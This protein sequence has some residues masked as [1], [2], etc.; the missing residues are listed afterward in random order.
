MH[1]RAHSPF[2]SIWPALAAACL[3]LVACDSGDGNAV[4]VVVIGEAGQASAN[5][6]FAS[7]ARLPL[8]A[9][10]VRSATAEGLVGLDEEGRVI[11]ALADRWIVTNDGR[12]YIFRLA[13]GTWAD[14]SRITGESVQV[15]LRQAL[16]AQNGTALGLDLAGITDVRAMA[17]RVVEIRLSSPM[18]DLLQLLAQPELGL[19]HRGKGAGPMALAR[20]GNLALLTPIP[21]EKRGVAPVDNWA[22]VARPLSLRASNG[23]EAIAAFS[24]GRADVVLGGTFLDLPRT[25]HTGLGNS[26]ARPDRVAGLF[27]LMVTRTTG[28]L[29]TPLMREAVAMAID[30]DALA[31][32]LGAAGWTVSTRI[33]SPGMEG[34]AGLVGERW[35]DLDIDSRRT[36]AQRRVSV[37]ATASRQP[38][39]LWINLPGG[40]GADILFT[41]LGRDLGAI[42]ISLQRTGKADQ[43]DVTL[44]DSVAR[45]PHVAWFLNALSCRASRPA[46]SPVADALAE[47]ARHA[48]DGHTASLLWAQAET[49]LTQNNGFIPLGPPIR[50]SLVNRQTSGFSINRLGAHPL[51]PLAMRTK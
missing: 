43:A 13:D 5:S 25:H 38:P 34:D 31:W 32:Q 20:R 15:A 51:M 21:P 10:L 17:G 24:A 44:V 8:A 3:G 19:M 4:K 12:H 22:D 28:L 9:G 18:P 45:Y 48:P 30:R 39:T 7:G 36:L 41:N 37:W 1:P 11:P 40:P 27:G 46:C 33:V 49:V 6:P 35:Q 2:R 50:W 42:G 29:S 16:D 14:N 47:R 23:A 26:A